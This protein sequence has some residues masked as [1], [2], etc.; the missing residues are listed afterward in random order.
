MQQLCYFLIVLLSFNLIDDSFFLSPDL[1]T[2]SCDDDE[3]YISVAPQ[4]RQDWSLAQQR[5][6]STAL[7]FSRTDG[8]S[9]GT[10]QE[11]KSRACL[12]EYSHFL[13][14]SLQI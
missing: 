11:P 13:V 4:T 2:V 14:M 1:A 3:E 6:V 10:R 5:P 7:P 9:T 12:G 8:V